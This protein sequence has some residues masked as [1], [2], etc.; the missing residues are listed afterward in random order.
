[1]IIGGAKKGFCPPILIIGGRVP[2]LPPQSLRLCQCT[3]A[4]EMLKRLI[5][6]EEAVLISGPC[7]DFQPPTLNEPSSGCCSTMLLV[8]KDYW[9]RPPHVSRLGTGITRVQTV[10]ELQ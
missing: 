9:R 3:C 10:E 7:H 8:I 1:M 5:R 2:G 6:R 4:P